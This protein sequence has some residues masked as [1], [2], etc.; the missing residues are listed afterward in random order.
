MLSVSWPLLLLVQVIVIRRFD[1]IL[2][3][4]FVNNDDNP[5]LIFM[6]H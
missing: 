3:V 1:F 4:D 5:L 2:A 6:P